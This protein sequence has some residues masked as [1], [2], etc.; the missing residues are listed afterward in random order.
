MI[1]PIL[2]ANASG[3]P[4]DSFSWLAVGGVFI[5]LV[6]LVMGAN[7][8]DDFLDRRKSKPGHPPNEQLLSSHEELSRR[9]GAIEG[10]VSEVRDALSSYT[11]TKDKVDSIHRKSIY[12]KIDKVSGELSGEMSRQSDRRDRMVDELRTNLE[13]RIDATRKELSEDI[14]GMPQ[15]LV[16]LLK[17]TG[18]I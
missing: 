13:N 3:N 4:T 7:A 9:V 14:K 15:Q 8:V 16:T 10:D 17:T 11:A 1:T 18:A 2:I 6:A 12:D 5:C